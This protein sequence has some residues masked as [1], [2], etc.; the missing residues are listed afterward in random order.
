MSDTVSLTL[1]VHKDDSLADGAMFSEK[2][3]G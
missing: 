2:K 1:G 3:L